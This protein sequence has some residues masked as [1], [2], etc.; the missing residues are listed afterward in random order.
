[1]ELKKAENIL[2][3]KRVL[4]T[5]GT[6][7]FG[8]IMTENLIKTGVKEI[9]L[10]SHHEDLQV[11]RARHFSDDRINFFSGDVRDYERCQ[12]ATK[13]IDFIFHAAALKHIEKIETHPMEAVK[14]NIAGTWNIKKAAIENYLS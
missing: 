12:E 6:G 10:M 4:I 1:M 2:G 13:N 3:G 14:T 8:T 7:S 9:R 11:Q 5:G